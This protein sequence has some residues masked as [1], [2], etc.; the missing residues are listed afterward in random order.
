MCLHVQFVHVPMF[1]KFRK[2]KTDLTQ[3]N[4]NFRWFAANGKTTTENF[5]SLAVYGN[6]K[7]K[8]VFLGRQTING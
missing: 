7:R 8:F 3:K 2:R 6:G 4:D 5:R 1:P